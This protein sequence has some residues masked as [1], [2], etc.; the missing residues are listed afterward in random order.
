VTGRRQL[1][2]AY[3]PHHPH[4]R[5]PG[6]PA[7]GDA[8]PQGLPPAEEGAREGLVD[9]RH[10]ERAL[11]IR[12]VEEA[13]ALQRHPQGLE[14]TRAGH[15]MLGMTAWP[16]VLRALHRDPRRGGGSSQVDL[17]LQSHR[18]DP[19]KRCQRL[20]QPV[21]GADAS[22]FV[23]VALVRQLHSRGHHPLGMEAQVHLGEAR[24]RPHEEPRPREQHEGQREL[25]HHQARAQRV[26]GPGAAMSP[27]E[28]R[29]ERGARGVQ[30]TH[31]PEE[32]RDA[33]AQ[34]H[35][36]EHHRQVQLR[37]GEAPQRG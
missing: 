26:A 3:V 10:R 19:R 37:P 24:E 8:A 13:A 29:Q 11:D 20:L 27:A 17:P 6:V 32:H 5:P 31:Q 1:A 16:C 18:L 12:R 23:R 7:K 35:G 15:A 2:V 28:Q 4:H 21:S 36:E 22:G 9:H 14:D 30:R 34:P 25:H 33:S